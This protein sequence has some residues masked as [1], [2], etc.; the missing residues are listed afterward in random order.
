[1][2]SKSVELKRENESEEKWEVQGESMRHREETEEEE[3][4]QMTQVGNQ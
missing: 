4:A 2:L 3:K 1:M